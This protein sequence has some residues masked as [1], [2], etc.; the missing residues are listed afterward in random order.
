MEEQTKHKNNFFKDV[1]K[2]IK[3]FDKYE[4]FALELPKKAM[5][6]FLKL[7]L[8]FCVLISLFYT[9]RIVNN[10][11][12]IRLSSSKL[13]Q[14]GL[15]AKDLYGDCDGY[16]IARKNDGNIDTEAYIKCGDYQTP[17]YKKNYR[18]R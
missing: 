7:L 16:A 17:G 3:D 15:F 1:L 2:S 4:D 14:V 18:L 6:Y 8:V 10:M 9:Y 5:L 12:E 11:G 13:F